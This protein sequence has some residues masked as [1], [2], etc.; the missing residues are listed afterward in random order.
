[1]KKGPGFFNYSVV[2]SELFLLVM[3]VV[4]FGFILQSAV[5]AVAYDGPFSGRGFSFTGSQ[6]PTAVPNPP[7]VPKPPTPTPEKSGNVLDLF[8]TVY[9][10]SA[11]GGHAMGALVGSFAWAGTVYLAVKF[12][13]PMFGANARLTNALSAASAAGIGAGTLTYFLVQ[14]GIIGTGGGTAFTG[15]SGLQLFGYSATQV[16]FLIGVGV[17]AA[18][19]VLLYKKEKKQVVELQCLPWEAP[20]GGTDCEKC[21][22][23]PLK[24][25]S[26]YRCKSLGQACEIVN[27]GTVEE[28]CVWVARNDVNSPTITPWTTVLTPKHHYAP[29][30]TRPAARGTKIVS[31]E[32]SNGCIKPFT[33]LQFGIITNEPS[34]CKI[35]TT[36]NATFDAMN[37]YFGESNLFRYN[38]TQQLRLP[39]P[40]SLNVEGLEV[41]TEGLYNFYVLCQDKNGNVNVDEFV[42]NFC[43]DKSPDTTP[44][45]IESTSI[46]SGSPVSFGTQTVPL[47]I[48]VNEPSQCKWSSQDKAY[49]LMENTMSC[50]THV[51]EQNARQ[52][53]P[54]STGLTGVRDRTPNDFY[55]RCKD[56]P[57][58]NESERNTN[59]E[60]YHFVLR[61][62]QPLNILSV[63]P[64]ATFTGSTDV[65]AVNLTVRTDDGSDEGKAICSFSSTGQ[66]GSFIAMFQSNN[67]LHS[68]TLALTSGTY[69]YSFRCV[70]AGGNAASANTTFS[71]FTDRRVP[72]VTRV[73]RESDVLKLVTDEDAVCSYSL[74]S[75]N[76]VFT[77]GIEMIVLNS[78]Q[79]FI[80]AAPWKPQ[81]SYYIK[82]RDL[83]GNEPAPNSCSLIARA[84]NIF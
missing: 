69:T 37:Y 76:F 47:T 35:E 20:L 49:D 8:T 65:V 51:Y 44:P 79:R 50:S 58:K 40:E 1:M 83:Y 26:E 56:Q 16:S 66:E 45:L 22:T 73:Y 59:Q 24:P 30:Q 61:G 74:T 82:C 13:A 23:D 42:F 5:P 77:E 14:N 52:Q 78:Q 54:C 68:Q 75:C 36:S 33:P 10:G 80:N 70:D 29:L 11:F 63:G 55:F 38:H 3:S 2:S 18:V 12:L 81:Q 32:T 21:N 72:Q 64:N 15:A 57:L 25:C 53:Y 34:Q 39:S 62:S 9:E 17:A 7:T 46:T 6:S 67:Y 43:V 41:P 48:Y 28:R 60:S 4:A 84:S 27:A 31:D 19:F 71:V